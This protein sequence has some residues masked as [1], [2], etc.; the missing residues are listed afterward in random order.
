M[1]NKGAS[2]GALQG[3]QFW[4]KNMNTD[5]KSS[6]DFYLQAL[7]RLGCVALSLMF[8]LSF[9]FHV[10]LGSRWAEP[11][12]MESWGLINGP[13]DTQWLLTSRVDL[14]C[15]GKVLSLLHPCITSHILYH[16]SVRPVLIPC[17]LNRC[18]N[19][20]LGLHM[21]KNCNEDIT[22]DRSDL[23]VQALNC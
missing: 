18:A 21:S 12:L 5:L 23:E 1:V 11:H 13:K 4:V 17:F 9:H 19:R 8:I 16:N 15:A 6:F 2:A 22:L 10:I 3:N 20:G 14:L 7:I